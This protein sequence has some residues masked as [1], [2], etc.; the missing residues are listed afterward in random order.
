M[1]FNLQMENN[2][3]ILWADDEID[4]L[5]PHI[6]FLKQKGYEVTTVNNGSDAID[7]VA[8]QNF[9]LVIL[10]ENMPGISGLETLSQIKQ[11][12]PDVPVIMITK[13]EEENIMNQAI[14]NKIA[15][16]LIKPVNPNQILMSLKKNLHSNVLISQK[17]TLD[18]Q[19]EF[20]RITE[21]IN[22]SYEIGDWFD[23]YKK[24]VFWEME[25]AQTETNMDELLLMQK[26]EANS[27]FCKFVKKNYEKWV[28][29]DN[30]PLMSHEIFKKKVF[31]L[32][33]EGEKVFFVLIDNFRLDQWRIVKPLLSEYFNVDE[34]LYCSILPTATQYARNAIFSG[35]M[36]VQIEKMFPDLWVDEESE[37]GKNINESP[38]IQTQLDR[39]RKR[40]KFSYNKVYE[41]S[42][43][44]K[45]LQNFGSFENYDLNVVVFNFIDMLSHARTES[46]TIRELASNN[47]AYRT[48]TESWFR[49][50]SALDLLRKIAESGY[51]VVL[52]TDHGTIRVDNPLKV[53]GDKNTNTNLRYKVGK[54]LSYN[55]RQVYEIKRPERYGLPSPN[56]SST[57]IF[58]TNGDFFAY[59]NNYNYYVQYYRDTFQ[60]GG[61]SMEEMLIPIIT[62]QPK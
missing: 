62:M 50:S 43:C 60:H 11:M 42:Y 23:L 61:I 46:K 38:L 24:L 4:L 33:D 49:H 32:L 35:L 48:L 41:S 14:G 58:A 54:N 59:P 30:H 55:E 18:Y 28:T 31:P 3:I 1:N 10:D 15:D 36:P 53:V 22:G 6:M 5:K 16:Y 21:Q 13:S 29:T 2:G 39:F 8:S 44:D 56:I 12:Q 9:D 19:Q 40:Y 27:A 7:R 52:T 45:L 51:K 47:A 34:D 17:A 57:Y 20:R 37:E 26:N 25:L